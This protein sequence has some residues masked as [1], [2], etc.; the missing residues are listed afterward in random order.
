MSRT[1]KQR[2]AKKRRIFDE[3][4][5][6]LDALKAHREGR[7]PLRTCKVDSCEPRLGR[8]QRLPAKCL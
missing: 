5:D 4:M 8:G 3:I 2:G 6:G 7:L 1:A